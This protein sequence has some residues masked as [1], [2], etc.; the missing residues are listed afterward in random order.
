MRDSHRFAATLMY[1]GILTAVFLLCIYTYTYWEQPFP[2]NWNDI[3]T[4]FY[5]I[6][7]VGLCAA[8]ATA[9][10]RKYKKS[11]KLY[12]IWRFFSLAMWTWMMADLIWAVYNL[13]VVEVP[14]VSGADFFYIL[15][16]CFFFIALHR[17]YRLLFRP[18]PRR[19]ALT[20]V[21]LS[22][23]VLLLTYLSI[24]LFPAP[25][26]GTTKIGLLINNFYPIGDLEIAAIALIFVYKFSRGFF[27]R[28]WVGLVI[29]VFS[30]SL[31]A[32]LGASGE[33]AYSVLQG[34]LAS[35]IA[36]T[37]YTAAYLV[38]AILLLN[39]YL[40]L[41]FGPSVAG[42]FAKFRRNPSPVD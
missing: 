5:G 30:D 16:Y 33:Y 13:V 21:G 31:Y 37:V 40:L 11:E 4:N 36:D 34:N 35:L 28:P 39:Y 19:D 38:L 26:P 25:A 23:A 17:Q 42:S 8:A 18:T 6:L 14:E 22:A 7:A 12:S 3:L 9:V 2:G 1:G 15:G 10:W 41:R 27:A 24:F 20:T 32:W 29:F